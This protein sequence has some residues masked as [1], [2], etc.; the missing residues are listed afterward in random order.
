[1]P[2]LVLHAVLLP[3]PVT[4]TADRK[5]GI[6]GALVGRDRRAQAAGGSCWHWV[7]PSLR[8]SPA[9]ELQVTPKSSFWQ[10]AEEAGPVARGKVGPDSEGYGLPPSATSNGEGEDRGLTLTGRIH[11][12]TC[13]GPGAPGR[14]G[15]SRAMAASW[16]DAP[17]PFPN[18]SA[19]PEQI[20]AFYS[21]GFDT[22]TTCLSF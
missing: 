19:S 18:A 21:C 11:G 6:P 10:A 17:P 4:G 3:E 9:P 16:E 20:Q 22:K 13:L 1:M 14:T 15:R 7:G 2:L 12:G 8:G 5:M